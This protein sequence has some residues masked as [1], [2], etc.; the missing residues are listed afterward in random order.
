MPNFTFLIAAL[1]PHADIRVDNYASGPLDILICVLSIY[2]CHL[3]LFI[4]HLDSET[5]EGLVIVVS[6]CFLE[7]LLFL[8]I[9]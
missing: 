9:S 8:R 6:V 7:L 4:I 5:A 1:F 2:S 3:Q